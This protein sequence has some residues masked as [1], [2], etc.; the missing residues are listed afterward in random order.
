MDQFGCD[1]EVDVNKN[2]D[3][4]TYQISPYAEKVNIKR[5]MVLLANAVVKPLAV[6]VIPVNALVA[7]RAVP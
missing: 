6:V 7:D 5:S 4:N 1:F 2:K 3:I